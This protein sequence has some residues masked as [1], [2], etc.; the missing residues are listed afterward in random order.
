[1]TASTAINTHPV[2]EGHGIHQ[3]LTVEAQQVLAR[4]MVLTSG[5]PEAVLG[6]V[7]QRGWVTAY[8][9]ECVRRTG[10][11]DLFLGPYVI[12]D[13]IGEGGM[14][15]VYRAREAHGDRVVALKVIHRHLVGSTPDALHRFKREARAAAMLSHPNVVHVYDAGQAHGRYYIAMELLEGTDLAQMVKRQGPL[16]VPQACGFIRQACLGLQHIHERGLI[17]RDIK[18][19][20]LM[21]AHA[22]RG[23]AITLVKIL[24]L[25]LVRRITTSPNPELTLENMTLGTPD[26]I[27]PEQAKDSSRVDIRADLYSLGCTFYHLLTGHAPFPQGTSFEKLIMHTIDYPVPVESLRPE[28]HGPVGVIVRKLMAKAPMERYQTPREVIMAL[29]TVAPPT[30]HASS[31]SGRPD[32]PPGLVL[33]DN[34][35]IGKMPS[36]PLPPIPVKRASVVG[37]PHRTMVPVRAATTPPAEETALVQQATLVASLKGGGCITSLAFTLDR[38]TLA[39]GEA[40]GKIRLWSFHD[41]K[42]RQVAMF[43][44]ELP[45]PGALAFD[46]P[47]QT[48]V[49]GSGDSDGRLEIWNVRAMTPERR[50]ALPAHAAAVTALAFAP[51]AKSFASASDD[52]HVLVWDVANPNPRRRTVLKGD[53]PGIAMLAMSP[54]GRALAA[55]QRNGK[56]R[57]WSL[58]RFWSSTTAVLAGH[59]GA[60]TSL[61]FAP[62]GR[63]LATGGQDQTVRVWDLR[64]KPRARTVLKGLSDTVRLVSFVSA[65]KAVSAISAGWQVMKWDA[66]TGTRLNE[67]SIPH[68]MI[69]SMAMTWDGRY[70]AAGLTSGRIHIYRLGAKRTQ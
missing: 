26:Y 63:S 46:P 49:A 27:A 39:S 43:E 24:D 28:L 1:M 56:I 54:D 64:G 55:G 38:N 19:S 45:F 2:R 32:Q 62:D 68:D 29:D 18:P 22:S 12:L 70:L 6:L 41:S 5:D 57:L 10:L 9:A 50:A 66:V 7:Q 67:R 3:L 30:P 35:R 47:G 44:T 60:I 23:P 8:Q 69:C 14:G 48:L 42:P 11:E 17:H 20:N 40:E 21:V 51:T 36:T 16:P 4:E 33:A 58:G 53:A 52:A 31:A 34:G 15:R 59:T 65:G 61:A 25:G 13:L 37:N